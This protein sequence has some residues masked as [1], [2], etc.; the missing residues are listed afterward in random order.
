VTII[1]LTDRERRVLD[2]IAGGHTVQQ[3]ARDSFVSANTI[4]TQVRS[5]YA[6]LG[7]NSRATALVRAAQHGLLPASSA[8]AK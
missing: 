3:M 6:K 8:T 2:R 5:L 4:K 7:A 1:E